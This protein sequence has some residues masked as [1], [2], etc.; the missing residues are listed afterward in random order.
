[1]ASEINC[2]ETVSTDTKSGQPKTLV[3]LHGLFG[4]VTNWESTRNFFKK[5]YRV[6]AVDFVLYDPK[7]PYQNVQSLT[8]STLR[9]MDQ[10]KIAICV[11]FG[12]SL[13][14]HVALNLA[15]NYPE[16]VAA[17]ILTGSAGLIERNY[18]MIAVNPDREYI[19]QRIGEVFY[20][21]SFSTDE[22][23]QEAL[24]ILQ[25]NRNKLRLIKLTRS[26]RRLNMFEHLPEVKPPVLLV[27]GRQDMVTPL[28]IGKIFE[29]R[30]P[31]AKLFV[32]DKCGHAPN[33]EKP[34]ELN[35]AAEAFFKEIGY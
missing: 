33:I 14:G 7:A 27:W 16:R 17:L 20:D 34:D 9:F 25:Y 19:E 13:G 29:S 23:V 12:N 21:Q 31:R 11:L 35:I 6:G 4:K 24:D 15:L 26:S 2:S 30:I 3:F 5:K 22:R 8:Q 18:S 32:I 10:H 28:D 1:M